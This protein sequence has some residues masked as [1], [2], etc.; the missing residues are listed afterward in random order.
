MSKEEYE[1]EAAAEAVDD[2]PAPGC[3][4]PSKA[5]AKGYEAIAVLKSILPSDPRRIEAMHM[6]R[7]WIIDN[8]G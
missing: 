5:I 4:A 2:A 1:A 7:D 6:V 3:Q 8:F